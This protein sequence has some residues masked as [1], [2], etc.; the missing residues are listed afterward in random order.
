M[1]TLKSLTDGWISVGVV[2]DDAELKSYAANDLFAYA[3]MKLLAEEARNRGDV[4][5]TLDTNDPRVRLA[6]E[7]MIR[8]KE[9]QNRY[10]NGAHM[11]V[12]TL[13]LWPEAEKSSKLEMALRLLK[14]AVEWAERH[15]LPIW[16]QILA[17]QK[18]FFRRAGFIEVNAFTL[19]LSEYG[20][21]TG[22]QEWVHMLYRAP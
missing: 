12:N 8:S 6:Y 2:R 15:G 22:T 19:D 16:T 21:V 17:G 18:P 20:N 7:L 9:G 13:S 10:V 4:S 3:F 5:G 14:K 11:V 1:L